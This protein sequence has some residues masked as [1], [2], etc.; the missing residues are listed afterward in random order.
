MSLQPQ[1]V[2]EEEVQSTE[3]LN[4]EE[5]LNTSECED[6][7]WKRSKSDAS[8]FLSGSTLKL[9][10]TNEQSVNVS[11]HSKVYWDLPKAVEASAPGGV[12]PSLG[13]MRFSDMATIPSNYELCNVVTKSKEVILKSG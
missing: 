7:S 1:V 6:Q 13:R 3:K 9:E 11:E 12:D 4:A 5:L 10:K 8:F 2:L